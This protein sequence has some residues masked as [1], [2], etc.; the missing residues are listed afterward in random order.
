MDFAATLLQNGVVVMPVFNQHDLQ[1]Y[2]N[3]FWQ[4]VKSFPEYKDPQNAIYIQDSF[5]ALGNPSSFH[6]PVV[7]HIRTNIMFRAVP[8]FSSIAGEKK[9]EQLI[10]RMSIRRQGT[11]IGKESWH[12]DQGPASPGDVIFG[13][14]INLD[15]E[16]EQRFSC[17]PGSHIIRTDVTGF[18]KET[19][20]DESQKK[21]YSIP[22]GH[23]IVFYQNI[24]H[25]VL[26]G[27]TKF[28][29]IRLYTGFRLTDSDVSLYNEEATLKDQGVITHLPGG[30]VVPM[31]TANHL[32]FHAEKTI[33]WSQNTFQPQCLETKTTP[34]LGQF[35]VVH[36]IMRS[37]REYNLP[38]YPEYTEEEKSVLR[39][40][41]KWEIVGQ[42]LAF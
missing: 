2:N 21:I 42:Q 39:P 28:T 19:P 41:R 26:P 37:L 20:V 8:L 1:L 6:N 11:T 17:I 29:S 5:G 36:R 16:N 18:V 31:Y 30:G 9:L 40:A 7:R 3:A 25:E 12:R 23:W 38:L 15:L 34:K 13:G 10:D 22:S 4:T 35:I 14:W 33:T 32:R 27:K 24:L